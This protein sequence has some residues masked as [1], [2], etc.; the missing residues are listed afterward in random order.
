[1]SGF[2]IYY[3]KPDLAIICGIKIGYGYDDDVWTKV[4]GKQ[5]RNFETWD[6]REGEEITYID[7]QSVMGDGRLSSF[8]ITS[9]KQP[10]KN[11]G[12]A[13]L[14]PTT[15]K[16]DASLPALYDFQVYFTSKFIIWLQHVGKYHRKHEKDYGGPSGR[17]DLIMVPKSCSMRLDAQLARDVTNNIMTDSWEKLFDAKFQLGKGVNSALDRLVDLDE[18]AWAKY[19]H[20]K[21]NEVVYVCESG[22]EI[23]IWT[24]DIGTADDPE[25]I[26]QIGY[27]SQN[28]DLLVGT[29]WSLSGTFSTNDIQKTS[30]AYKSWFTKYV[31][32]STGGVRSVADEVLRD[33]LSG[34]GV[35]TDKGTLT[36]DYGGN[37]SATDANVINSFVIGVWAILACEKFVGELVSGPYLVVDVL[38]FDRESDWAQIAA[39]GD[40]DAILGAGSGTVVIP[41]PD[42][43][44]YPNG[45]KPSSTDATI[46]FTTDIFLEPCT[47][48]RAFAS[49]DKQPDAFGY[50][51]TASV[52]GDVASAGIAVLPSN[53]Q[54]VQNQLSKLEARSG[55]G[56]T[57]SPP[58]LIA[59]HRTGNGDPLQ[60]ISV[61]I[62]K[63]A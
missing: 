25:H 46:F 31:K 43:Y 6:R 23:Y 17:G 15:G 5:T 1:M 7:M 32:D 55:T 62:G 13:G 29:E 19:C 51:S 28:A 30:I 14:G 44:Q 52:I 49:I 3:E 4:M 35:I 57:S 58:T 27:Y 63:Y 50:I 21:S 61:L 56:S 59:A 16:Y 10:A 26:T 39:D 2:R 48:K 45:Y 40:D 53:K 9:T 18:N 38:N 20:P 24:R 54:G 37:M 12:N 41:K 33:A 11:Y 8:R 34:A 47:T 36:V 60:K 42:T 22:G